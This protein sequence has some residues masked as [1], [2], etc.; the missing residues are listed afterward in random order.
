[1]NGNEMCVVKEYKFVNALLTKIILKQIK[2]LEIVIKNIFI[3][4]N[5]NLYMILNLQILL[6]MN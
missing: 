1:M 3:I 2:V 5:M 6:T 4:L